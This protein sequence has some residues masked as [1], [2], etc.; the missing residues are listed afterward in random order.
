MPT[1]PAG[2][3]YLQ[4]P[5]PTV[6][7][8]R[9]LKAMAMPMLDHRGPTFSKMAAETTQDLKKI[10]KTTQPVIIF[11]SSGTGAWQSAFSNTLSTGDTV[12]LPEVGQFSTLWRMNAEAMGLTVI[13]IPGDWR[14]GIDAS[15]VEDALK[16]DTDGKIK[17]VLAT[18]NE[19]AT[20][21]TSDIPAV[22]KA[23]DSAGHDAMLFVDTISSL[24][25]TDYQHDNWGA[26]VTICGSQKGFMLPPGLSF[27]A[28]S[29]RAQSE[30]GKGNLPR[31]YFDWAPAIDAAGNGLYPYTPPV[32]LFYGL[33]EAVDMILEE[34]LDNIFA[35]HARLAK[36][37]RAAVAAWGFENQSINESE[38]SNA[39]TAVRVPEDVDA[40]AF[41][42]VVL[43]NFDMSLAAGLGKVAGKVFRIGHLGYQNDLSLMGAL[44]GVEMGLDIA[45]IKHDK[46]GV[47]A[48]M[49]VLKSTK[50]S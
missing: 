49:D 45:G 20:G 16:A 36:A 9:I 10:F 27:L 48:A 37:T 11:P 32:S 21:V 17:A 15:K 31:G 7:P 39:V 47:L 34:G 42:A 24:V 5:G 3:Y 50:A 41:R 25:A 38:H 4:V 40:D 2:R 22:R 28:L 33:R 44:S 12:L 1:S 19:T 23:M 26:D 43:E 18:H 46:G 29:E 8:D 35:R 6:V 14:S 30:Y 13:E